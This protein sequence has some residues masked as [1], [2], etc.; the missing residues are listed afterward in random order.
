MRPTVS[1]KV[2]HFVLIL[3]MDSY[4]SKKHKFYSSY[5]QGKT[6]Y[7]RNGFDEYPVLEYSNFI[8]AIN[9]IQINPLTVVDIGCGNGLLLKHIIQNS[10]KQIIPY[11]IDFIEES[12]DEAKYRTLPDF[13]EN[14]SCTNAVSYD[15]QKSFDLVLFDVSLLK[16]EDS[17]AFLERIQINGIPYCIVY[18]YA[19]VME[20][21]QISNVA[22]LIPSSQKK[23]IVYS[24]TTEK[25][26]LLLMNFKDM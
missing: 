16:K 1:T 26:S 22:D 8:R 12:I 6:E 11:G 23:H 13:K 5:P 4:Y 10:G 25:I 3:F 17:D 7:E 18:L 9:Y 14:F 15:F 20:I 21:M 2:F 19:D 24:T